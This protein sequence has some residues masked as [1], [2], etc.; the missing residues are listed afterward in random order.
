MLRS[1]REISAD[2]QLC[3]GLNPRVDC[4]A[5]QGSR[6]I[7][8]EPV[9]EMVGIQ[10]EGMQVIDGLGG[11]TRPALVDLLHSAKA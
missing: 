6:G 11:A 1:V 7:C 9:T 10:E 3:R 5:G 4:L 8:R 2:P